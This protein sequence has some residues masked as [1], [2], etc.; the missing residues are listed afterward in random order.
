YND[1][2]PRFGFAL[3]LSDE[4]GVLLRGGYGIYYDRMSGDLAETTVGQPPFSFKQSLAG[5]QN[6]AATMQQPYNPM[7]PPTSSFPIFLPR[8]PGG[9]LSLA[10]IS[11][12]LHDPYIQQ[13]NLNLQYEF[14]P[15]LH[16]EIGYVGSKST[17]LAGCVE[18]NQALLASPQNPIGGLTANTFE[19]VV[20]RLPFEGIA[21]GSY[22][23]QTTFNA[24]YNSLQTSVTRRLVRGL[25]FLGSY[26]WSK[27][28]N[29]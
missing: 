10:A 9:G 2:S 13:Y 5:A 26:T 29:A 15:N 28:L 22:I 11:P 8:L 23:C 3:R 12:H 1:I 16:F 14:A 24:S 27:E 25:E 21:P 4:P 17:H 18:F 6:G 19:N 7:L 20:Q